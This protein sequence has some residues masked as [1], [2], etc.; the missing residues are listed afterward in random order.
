MRLEIYTDGASSGNPGPAAIGVV[1]R[2]EKGKKLTE[3]SQYLGLA[4]NN[5][6][7]YQAVLTALKAAIEFKAT[8]ITL[9]LD[10]ELIARQLTGE[11]RV[12]SPSLKNLYL[13]VCKLGRNF[14]NLTIVPITHQKNKEAHD[15][16]KATLKQFRRCNA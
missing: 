10:S 3:L 2:E 9:Y 14:K 5:Q 15:L 1:I 13:E 16:A 6:A 4:T 8:E 11:Y 7:E 12:R